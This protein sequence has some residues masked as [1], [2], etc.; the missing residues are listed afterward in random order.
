MPREWFAAALVAMLLSSGC[1]RSAQPIAADNPDEAAARDIRADDPPSL[2]LPEN[3]RPQRPGDSGGSG[4]AGE[5]ED[6]APRESLVDARRAPPVR[7]SQVPPAAAPD[8]RPPAAGAAP[9]SGLQLPP[10]GTPQ[11]LKAFLVTA[12]R[13]IQRLGSAETGA[14]EAAVVAEIKRVAELKQ[15]AAERMLADESIEPQ[16]QVIATRARMQALSHKAALGDIPA[17]ETLESYAVELINHPANDIARDSRSVLIGFALERLQGGVTEE[18]DEVLRFTGELAS[19]PDLLDVSSMMAMQRAVV[20]LT[21]YGYDDAAQQVRDQI[22]AAFG[23]SDDPRLTQLATE[24]LAAARFDEIEAM[25]QAISES[26]SVTAE[27]WRAKAAKVAAENPDLMTLQYLASL[28]LQMEAMQRVEQAAAVYEAIE[29]ELIG[30]AKDPQVA[31]AA[32]EAI[33]AFEAR[34][35]VIG[36]KL[37]IAA[38]SDLTGAPFRLEDYAGKIVL[39]V[40]WAVEDPPSLDA[41][42]SLEQLAGQHGDRVAMVGVNM[43][44]SPAG[45]SRAESMARGSMPWVNIAAADDQGSGYESTLARS[46]GVVALPTVVVL[47]ASGEVAAVPLS[48]DTVEAAL[49]KL[50]DE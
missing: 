29:T 9:V 36:E 39:M 10:G 24:F 34:R 18:P 22:A 3:I 27:Q 43:D 31:T 4:A 7:V 8:A 47:N 23:D 50:A 38:T 32:R 41:L 20:V 15:Q 37:P 6:D 30:A 1:N 49:K 12:D 16:D 11:E 46:V 33:A 5:S 13:E 14:A 19:R 45:R 42:P 17:A 48:H 26:D 40:F 2:R 44:I 21:Q 35:N 28:A 25:R